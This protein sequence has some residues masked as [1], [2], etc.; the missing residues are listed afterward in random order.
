MNS[1]CRSIATAQFFA[2]HVLP[3]ATALEASIVTGKGGE[4]VLA[5]AEDQF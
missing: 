5:L 3:Q 1:S 2:E 4:R